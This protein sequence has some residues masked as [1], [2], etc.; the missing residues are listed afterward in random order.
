MKNVIVVEFRAKEGKQEEVASLFREALGDTRAYEGC[1][2]VDVYFEPKT[3]TYTLIE[4]W[5]SL[6]H[7]D[8][9]LQ[10]RM[11][12]GIQEVVEPLLDGGMDGFLKSIKRLGPVTEL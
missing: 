8:A 6:E 9:Y 12:S 1:I 2:S 5:E 7:Y 4:D 3:N 10:W 11:D